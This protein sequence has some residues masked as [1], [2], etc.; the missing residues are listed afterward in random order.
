MACKL[1]LTSDTPEYF[2]ARAIRLAQQGVFTTHPN[3]RVGCV[4]VSDGRIVGEGWHERAGEAHAEV[5]ALA[6][7]G[8]LARGST[9][10]VTLEPCAHHGRTP[11]C[12]EA[13]VRAG[14]GSVV[15]ACED[16]NPLVDGGG[17]SRLRSA[18]IGVSIG[19]LAD[20]ARALNPGFLRRMSGGLPWVRIKT[21]ASLDGKIS[22]A[23][24]ESQWI[25]GPEARADVQTLRAR[26]SAVLTGVGTVIADNPLLNVRSAEVAI[27]SQ[28]KLRQPLRIVWDRTLR[29]PPDSQLLSD[30]SS[31]RCLLV[32]NGDAEIDLQ[33]RLALEEKADL[34][35]LAADA[36]PRELLG[37][38]A[39]K[40][41]NE[42]LVE[43]GPGL[44]GSFLESGCWD[45]FWL[46]QA[47]RLLGEAGKSLAPLKSVQRLS[48][49]LDFTVKDMRL[50]GGDIRLILT[51]S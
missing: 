24:G 7:A 2:M 46:Y 11:P 17:V 45:E 32:F 10:Y 3:P 12:A 40:G 30:A 1:S 36:G 29:T 38:L 37:A 33:R 39:N 51:R 5:R 34:L 25:T 8:D 22:L 50:V 26:S 14:V 35:P 28:G 23:S 48:D 42:L 31:N 13:L 47:P 44:T 41:V 21:G 6:Q 9:V 15:I 4:I 43:A 16:P 20:E 19:C 18:G 49:T 27:K